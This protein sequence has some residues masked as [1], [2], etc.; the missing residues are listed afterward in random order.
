MGTFLYD[1]LFVCLNDVFYRDMFISEPYIRTCLHGHVDSIFRT[2]VQAGIA[3]LAMVREMY[4]A[5]ID[6][7][8]ACRTDFR[9][10]TA[11]D[12]VVIYCICKGGVLL[13]DACRRSFWLHKGSSP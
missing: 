1:T 11:A 6:G 5:L 9:T 12:A 4:A 8:I 10:D 13:Q 3:N 2:V 7:D